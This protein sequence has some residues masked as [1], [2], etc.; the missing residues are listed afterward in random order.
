MA[1]AL[2]I[3]LLTPLL[4][5]IVALVGGGRLGA[6][7]AWLALLPPLLACTATL[8][9]VAQFVPGTRTVIEWAWIPSL[10]LNLTFVI[11]GL[12]L[13]FGLVVSGMGVLVVFYSAHYLDH[14]YRE[15]GRFYCYLMLF[16]GAMLG[17]VFAGNLLLLFVCWELT[18]VASFLLIGFLHHKGESRDGAR[19][20][21]LVTGGTGLAMLAGIVLLG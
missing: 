8:W 19:M 21:L 2:L 3:I 14:H 10:G 15:H 16:M 9:L 6:R 20:A 17:T 12:A 4:G 7:T 13:F 5:A 18:G 11:D 1:I